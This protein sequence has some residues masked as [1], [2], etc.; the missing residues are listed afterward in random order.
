MINEYGFIENYQ[1]HCGFRGPDGKKWACQNCGSQEYTSKRIGTVKH[2]LDKE[3]PEA[4]QR[5]ETWEMCDRCT[6]MVDNTPRDAAGNKVIV[7]HPM[8]HSYATGG[9]IESARQLSE[10]CKKNNMIQAPDHKPKYQGM[11]RPS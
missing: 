10:W 5:I 11:R 8:E 7:T 9:P 1:S 4:Q 2:P 6:S 3:K